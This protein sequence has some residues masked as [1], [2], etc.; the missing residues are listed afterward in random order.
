MS[1]KLGFIG[2][3][4]MAKAIINGC[5]AA[6]LINKNDIIASVKTS[7]SAN[8]CKNELD[9]Q[10]VTKNNEV[11]NFAD[12]IFLATKPNQV[13]NVLKEIQTYLT[14][15]KLIISLAAGIS[16]QK[17]EQYI[18]STPLIRVM[19]NTPVLIK[20]GISATTKGRF[21]T[22]KHEQL[23]HEILSKIGKVI[24]VEENQIDVVT[25]ISGS[26]PAFFYQIFEDMAQAGAKLGLDYNKALLLAVQT[27]IGAAK[28]TLNRTNSV[29]DLVASVATKGGCTEV[30]INTMKNLKSE[31]LFF[32]IIKN[33]TIKAHSLG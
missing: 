27:A 28:M 3:G 31:D 5:L 1:N 7:E 24:S 11:V 29:N 22:D 23:V 12:I 15:D 32:E 19:P 2:C 30:G 25:A 9:I 8:I 16:T 14:K 26:G 17:I 18:G 13:E 20:E 33:T 10:I 6:N 4:K 21:A